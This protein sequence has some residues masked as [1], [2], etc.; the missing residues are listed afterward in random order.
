[1]TF[2]TFAPLKNYVDLVLTTNLS[3]NQHCALVDSGSRT[4]SGNSKVLYSK[5]AKRKEVCYSTDIPGIF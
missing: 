4:E 5:S 3:L 1:M 2:F